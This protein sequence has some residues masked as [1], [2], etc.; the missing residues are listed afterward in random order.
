MKQGP[1]QMS[2]YMWEEK[3]QDDSRVPVTVQVLRSVPDECACEAGD[4]NVG[5]I[6]LGIEADA[7]QVGCQFGLNLGPSAKKYR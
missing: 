3:G 5:D 6:A 1:L 7:A 4:G 2:F